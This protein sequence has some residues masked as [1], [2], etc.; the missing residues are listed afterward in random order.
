MFTSSPRQ[1]VL[2]SLKITLVLGFLLLPFAIPTA[3]AHALQA[4]AAPNSQS[5]NQNDD[6]VILKQVQKPNGTTDVTVRI[7]VSPTAPNA[8]NASFSMSQDT[9]IT[10]GIPDGNY[11]S[12][13]NLA[14]GYSSSGG[15]D[16]LRMLLQFDLSSIPSNATVNNASVYVYQYAASGISNMGFQSQ[17][18]VAPWDQYN[19]T[20]NNANYLGGSALPVGNFPSTLGWLSFNSTNVFQTWVSGAEP[21]YGVIITGNEDPAANSSRYFYSSNAG[22]ARPYADISYTTGCSYTSDPTSS[23]NPL[24]ATSPSAFTV[25]WTGTAYTPSGCAANGISSYIV[26]YQVNNGEFIKWLDGVS[27]TSAQFDAAS[28]GIANGSAVGFRSQAIDYYGNKTPAG[29][30]TAATT[31]NA[32]DTTPPSTTMN[33]LPQHTTSTSFWVSWTGSDP[34]GSGVAYYNLQYQFNQGAWQTLI[35]NT[36]Q[37][38]FYLQNVQTGVYGFRV[39]AVDYAGNAQAWPASAQTSTTVL[40]NPLAVIQPFNP[41]ILQSTA[42]VTKSFNVSWK[43]YTPPGTYL[44]TYTIKYRYN[45]GSSWTAWT[46]W[47]LLPFPA[48][49]TSDAFNWFDLG[50][51]GEATYQFQ[52]T[53]SNNLNQPPVELPS[54]YWQSMIVDMQDRY[55]FT[56]LPIILNNGKPSSSTP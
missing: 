41:P 16:A 3:P 50:L 8:P 7:Y 20:W 39:Q 42:P 26:W 53:A 24:P 4:D 27:Y 44:T 48:S 38:S 12:A 11:G 55:S 30:A 19:A 40:V 43:G 14:I 21:N 32:A 52:A 34:G 23:V 15:L 5:P 51:P 25:S 28:L 46:L 56:Y 6:V 29:N 31:I 47:S 1:T 37:T 22:T 2:T 33:P 9:Y 36:P 49:Q 10:S 45:T 35:S 18:A 13:G 17:Y 54:Q